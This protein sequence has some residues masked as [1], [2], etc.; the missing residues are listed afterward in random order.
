MVETHERADR[1]A[2]RPQTRGKLGK[3]DFVRLPPPSFS[4]LLTSPFTTLLWNG[5]EMVVLTGDRASGTYPAH[6]REGA[7]L[8]A[9]AGPTATYLDVSVKRR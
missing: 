3:N 8:V 7:A 1:T 5:L 4:P 9:P 2:E 6:G